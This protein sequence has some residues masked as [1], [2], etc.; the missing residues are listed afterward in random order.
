LLLGKKLRGFGEGFFNGYGGKVEP[1]EAI[2]AG[3][4]RELHEEAGI[5]A[6]DLH[7]RGMLTFWWSDLPP[8]EPAWEVHVFGCTAFEGTPVTT[9]EMAPAWFDV[10]VVKDGTAVEGLPFER[11]WADDPA[12]Y[13]LFLDLKV[14]DGG[15]IG[16]GCSLAAD[17][18]IGPLF[19]GCFQF[20][21]V[22][23]LVGE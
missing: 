2:E 7:R 8:T 5:T 22:T 20:K 6:T 11:M 17:G 4:A 14:H 10:E 1:G 21:N 3:A 9:D 23:E 15:G 12:W 16:G 13:P 18:T 19:E